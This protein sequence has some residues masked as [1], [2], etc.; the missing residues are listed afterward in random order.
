METQP[1]QVVSLASFTTTT[2]T[3]IIIIIIIIVSKYT[4]MRHV[5]K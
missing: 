4:C 5:P 3:I 2:T 1:Q